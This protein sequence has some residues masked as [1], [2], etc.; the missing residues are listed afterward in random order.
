MLLAAVHGQRCLITSATSGMPGLQVPYLKQNVANST[1]L[2]S[3]EGQHVLRQ[4]EELNSLDMQLYRLGAERAGGINCLVTAAVQR[5]GS[6][7][8]SWMAA[9]CTPMPE[10]SLMHAAAATRRQCL[11]PSN[12]H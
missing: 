4:L 12:P 3:L 5:E 10:V 6:C 11:H 8:T 9:A 7:A 2:A 1:E